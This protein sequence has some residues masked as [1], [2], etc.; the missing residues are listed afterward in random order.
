MTSD[1]SVAAVMSMLWANSCDSHLME[2][3]VGPPGQRGPLHD[4][5]S[6]MPAKFRD[7]M[8]R[9]THK[10]GYDYTHIDGKVIKRRVFGPQQ[11]EMREAIRP[12]GGSDPV[13]RLVDL[14][15]QGIWGEVV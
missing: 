9:T 12:P 4:Y 2:P 15:D 7:R 3:T 8:P 13:K 14:D 1:A 5:T 11:M 10:N 6:T